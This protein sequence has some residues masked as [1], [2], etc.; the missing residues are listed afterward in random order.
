MAAYI[1]F[2]RRRIYVHSF[3]NEKS[4]HIFENLEMIFREK[5]NIFDSLQW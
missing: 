1:H 3:S 4:N 2:L 5:T